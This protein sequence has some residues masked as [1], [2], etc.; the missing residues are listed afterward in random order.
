MLRPLNN[1]KVY[2]ND[3][4]QHQTT[5][6]A[7]ESFV[8]NVLFGA[9]STRFHRPTSGQ[10]LNENAQAVIKSMRSYIEKSDFFNGQPANHLLGKREQ[11]EAFCR[12]IPDREYAIFFPNG[13]EVEID[14]ND[15]L[16]EISIEWLDIMKSEWT[17]D[18]NIRR[19]GSKVLVK[20][21]GTANWLAHIKIK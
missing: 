10:G 14:I 9:A 7:I 11:G 19:Q 3:G 6:N 21:P 18:G 20:S 16:K 2:G 12:A 1:V 5:Q 4:G 13:G 17:Q 15:K 8:K